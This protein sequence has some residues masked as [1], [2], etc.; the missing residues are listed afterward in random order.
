MKMT[1]KTFLSAAIGGLLALQVSAQTQVPGKAFVAEVSGGITL[2]R[3]GTVVELR[4]G[5]SLPIE[6]ARIETA[7]GASAIFVFS[8]GTSLLVD[9]KTIVEVLRFVQAPFP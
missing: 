5:I 3:E 1:G 7:A 2:I 8:N 6:G 9:E 4:K